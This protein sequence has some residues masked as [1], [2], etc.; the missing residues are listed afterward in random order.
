MERQRR[1]RH[2]K[3]FKRLLEIEQVIQRLL[4]IKALN[5]DS[6]RGTNER[7]RAAAELGVNP[8]TITRWMAAYEHDP[9]PDVFAGLPPGRPSDSAFR[10]SSG[11]WHAI[12]I[13]I[14]PFQ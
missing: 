8:I 4:Q 9:R 3:D 2:N 1:Q 10:N 11:R 13:S 12:Y 6:L 7:A 14:Q 5:N